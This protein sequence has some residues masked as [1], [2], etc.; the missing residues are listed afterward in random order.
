[1]TETATDQLASIRAMLDTGLHSVRL[2]SH[3][4]IIWGLAGG[5]LCVIADIVI[6]PEYLPVHWQRALAILALVGGL[7]T[8]AGILDYRITH[9]RRRENDETVSFVQHQLTKV[10]WLLMSL[11]VLLTIGMEFFGG[12]YMSYSMWMF[13]VGLALTIHGLF[14]QQ[15][16]KWYGGLFI[17][18]AI[19]PLLVQVPYEALRWI[20]AAAFGIG[21]PTAGLFVQRSRASPLIWPLAWCALVIAAAVGIYTVVNG[22][23]EPK[24]EV[25]SLSHYLDSSFRKT[26]T[27][28]VNIPSGTRI[29]VNINISSDTLDTNSVIEI[30][31]TLSRSLDIAL[32]EGNPIG[33]YRLENGQW[34]TVKSGLRIRVRDLDSSMDSHKGPVISLKVDISAAR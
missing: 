5:L 21:L 1:M 20:A 3:S 15:P 31:I 23:H 7:L 26:G 10:W 25:I 34:Q 22:L 17:A 29:P 6:S 4:L 27:Q 18:L 19:G 16:L 2:D 30:P 8:I 14:S 33:W 11:G 28:L 13:L 24:G 12:G 32:R 9:R